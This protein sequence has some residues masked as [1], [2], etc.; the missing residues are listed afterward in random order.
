MRLSPLISSTAAVMALLAC[1]TSIADLN[2][3]GDHAATRE[4]CEGLAARMAGRWPDASTRIT[5]TQFHAAPEV[6]SLSTF[7]GPPAQITVPAHCELFGVL[8]ERTGA[9]GQRYAIRFHLRLPTAWNERFFFQAGGG[10]NGE[11]GNAF[12]QIAPKVAP[13]LVQG[14]AV[15]SQDSGHDNATNTDPN[16]GGTT[17]FGF[18]AQARADYGHASL[19]PVAQAAKALIAA[20]YADRPRFSYFVGCSKGGAEGMAITQRYPEEFDGVLAAA[21]GFSLP[22]A[23]LAEAWDVQTLGRAT[24]LTTSQSLAAAFTDADLALAARAV[25][26]ACDADDG[27]ADG[28]VGAFAQCAKQKVSREM[29]GVQCARGKAGECLSEAQIDALER[30]YA[31]PV[32]ASGKALYSDWPWDAGLA[33]SAWRL[34]KLGSSEP[35]FPAFNIKLGGASLSA[36]FTTPPTVVRDDPEAQLAFIRSFDFTRDAHKIYATDAQ[37]PRSAWDDISARSSDLSRF[38]ARGG[39]LLVPHGVSDAVFSIN[40]TLAW[41]REVDQRTGGAAA[42]FV[43]VFPVPGMG[44]CAGGPATDQYDA[45]AALMKW[46]EH[47]EAPERIVAQAGPGTPWPGRQRPLCPYPKVARYNGSGNVERAESFVCR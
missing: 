1:G 44:H 24:D 23:A 13:A 29:R 33:S 22:R 16:R 35:A 20:Y 28:I 38:R 11:I 14:F 34:W 4:Q 36:V 2:P 18:D 6:I 3:K 10:T 25:L 5:S 43:R 17:A 41:Y 37:F 27:L 15:V 32:D 7:G 31:G 45:F 21:P 9:L 30:V 39:K 8:R 46:V 42:S 40:D 26:S 12:G 19:Q 47:D